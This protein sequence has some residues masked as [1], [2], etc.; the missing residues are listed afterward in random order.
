MRRRWTVETRYAPVPLHVPLA[1]GGYFTLRATAGDDRG[2]AART[3]VSFYA[4]GAGYTAWARYDH[5]RIDL[6][7]EQIGRAHG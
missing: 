6:V 1:S 3:T 2:R 5:N 4:L 7:P